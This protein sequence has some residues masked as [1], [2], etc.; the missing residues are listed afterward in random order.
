MVGANKGG[1]DS[2]N[3]IDKEKEAM[4]LLPMEE[5]I[6]PPYDDRIF[7]ALLTHPD[8]EPALIDL[9]SAILGSRVSE[10]QIFNNELPVTDIEEKAERLDVNCVVDGHD[11][12]NVEMQGSRIEELY[13]GHTNF[14]NKYIYYMTDLHSSQ[15]SKGI[16][17]YN[18]VRTY[19][20]TFS[21]HIVF[22]KHEGFITHCR[23]YAQDGELISDQINMIVI[24]LCKL[25]NVLNKPV[26]QM[27]PL[28]MWSVFLGHADDFKHRKLINKIIERNEVLGMAG[29]VLTAISKDEDERARIIS[30]RKAET[31]RISNLLTVEAR[32]K[33]QGEIVGIMKVAE[34]MKAAGKTIDEIAS[35]TGLT[36]DDINKLA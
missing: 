7:K 2:D 5:D 8:A 10:V 17:Y 16:Q 25:G 3:L 33:A 26:D 12:V 11:Q 29:A 1:G 23:M 19:Q 30:R 31:D 6:L 22:P 27:T 28:E 13:D 21:K 14:I 32:G 34:R 4:A 15:K 20:V 35:F 36:N 18:L 24:E 9:L